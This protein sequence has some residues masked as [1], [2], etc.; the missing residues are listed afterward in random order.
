MDTMTRLLETRTK[1]IMDHS[2][3]ARVAMMVKLELNDD[4]DT[5]R[6]DGLSIQFSPKFVDGLS[7]NEL[8]GLMAHETL[9]VAHLHNFRRCRCMH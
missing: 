3:Y 5:A 1:M 8:K 6:T 9:H 4:I 2:F 7:N